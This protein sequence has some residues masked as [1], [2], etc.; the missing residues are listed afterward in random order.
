[1]CLVNIWAFRHYIIK[2]IGA[3]KITKLNKDLQ[4]IF[5]SVL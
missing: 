1:M 5:E 2:N 3:V 4:E